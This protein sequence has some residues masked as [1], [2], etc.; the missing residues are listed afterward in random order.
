MTTAATANIATYS[1]IHEI[2]IAPASKTLIAGR[3]RLDV[4]T[5][6]DNFT[7][8]SHTPDP[9]D[10]RNKELCCLHTKSKKI[11]QISIELVLKATWFW[12]IFD[13]SMRMNTQ[14]CNVVASKKMPY[15]W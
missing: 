9:Y 8:E 10:R 3:T 12:E 14:K 6:P 1:T 15:D 2:D 13:R 11:W 7:P 4:L 5:R